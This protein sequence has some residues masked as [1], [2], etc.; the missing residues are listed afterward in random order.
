M[1]GACGLRNVAGTRPPGSSGPNTITLSVV[2][3]CG[4]LPV[5]GL[6]SVGGGDDG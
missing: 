6:S 5:F 4:P 3:A 2:L 1:T